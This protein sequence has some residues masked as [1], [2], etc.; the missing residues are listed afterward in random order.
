VTDRTE[1]EA[2]I[3]AVLF[4]ASEPLPR[5][6]V[7]EIFNQRDR[8]KAEEALDAV[9]ARYAAAPDRG[10]VAERVAGGVRIATRPEFNDY[11][12]K[13]FE[14]TGRNKLSMAAL[15]TL[16]IVAYR[17]PI[18]APEVQDL[19]GVNSKGVLST[20][21]ENRLIR[22]AGRK[23]VVGKPFMYRTTRDFLSHFAL[24]SLK[25]LPPLEEFEE[26]LGL[27]LG[28]EVGAPT[29]SSD[30]Q[31]SGSED[32]DDPEGSELAKEPAA[33]TAEEE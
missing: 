28:V 1:I 30:A 27:E 3:E 6:K 2:A 19:R 16:A 15:E 17:Q 26:M 29:P 8:A 23:E 7:L 25:E 20:L 11:L 32:T 13:M 31:S 9:L 12:R 24:D 14:V 33:P 21:L 18:T 22:L 10:I 5:A 4:V